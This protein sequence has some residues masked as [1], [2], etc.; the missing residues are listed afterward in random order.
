MHGPVV[1]ALQ[2]RLSVRV[3]NH[4]QVRAFGEDWECSCINGTYKKTLPGPKAESFEL[5]VYS[6][7]A[8]GVAEYLKVSFTLR[9]LAE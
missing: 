8:S 1:T 9:R 4:F 5:H 2:C 6:T 7:L 3:F